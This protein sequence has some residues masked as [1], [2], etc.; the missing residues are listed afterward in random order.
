MWRVAQLPRNRSDATTSDKEA[1]E[2]VTILFSTAVQPH[3]QS[4][5][6]TLISPCEPATRTLHDRA[7]SIGFSTD[8]SV[9]LT[10]HRRAANAPS[11][12]CALG[13]ARVAPGQGRMPRPQ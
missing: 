2:K 12:I 7:R 11:T 10:T 13:R 4:S 5:I 3:L 9:V 1:R 8:E 6:R